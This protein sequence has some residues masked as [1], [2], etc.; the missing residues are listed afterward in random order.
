MNLFYAPEISLYPFLSGEE[1][2]HAV[3][4]L[5]VKEGEKIHITDGLGNLFLAEIS[6]ANSKQCQVQILETLPQQNSSPN[7]LHIA[8]APT[9]NIDRFEYFVEKATEIGIAQITPLLCRFSE[10][11]I[12]NVERLNKII[13]SAAKQSLKTLFPVINQLTKFDDL[14]SKTSESQRFIAHCYEG[15]K[16]L[17]KNAF[18]HN[19]DAIV[20]IGPEGDFSTA[21]LELAIR[22]GFSPVSL[23]DSRL[24]TETAG[25][26]ACVMANL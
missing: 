25:I 17:L 1:S 18:A 12:L 22:N 14:V 20:L 3:K 8:I 19:S 15:E 13:V 16:L 5:R 24:R 6:D 2:F 26:V 4:V 11:K 9:K 21:E 10:R 7:K 23:G